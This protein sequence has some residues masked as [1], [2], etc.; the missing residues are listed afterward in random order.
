MIAGTLSLAIGTTALLFAVTES[1]VLRPFPFPQLDR[2]VGIGAAFPAAN[3]PLKFFEALSAPEY[4][5]I[6]AGARALTAV[7]GFDLNNE[8][9]VVNGQPERVFTAFV[10]D[11]PFAAL[12]VAPVAGRAITR[13]ELD[14]NAPVAVVSHS[15][16]LSHFAGD[17]R[18]VGAPVK[19]SGRTCTIVGVMPSR[20]RVYGTDLWTPMAERPETLPRDRRQFNVIARIAPGGSLDDA[21][22][23]LEVIAGRMA[24]EHGRAV[25]EYRGWSLTARRW[26]E[27]DGSP[28]DAALMTALAAATLVLLL[29][30]A[31]VA[32]M[33]LATGMERSRDMAVRASLGASRARL[34]TEALTERL[35]IVLMGGL[36]GVV[37]MLWGLRALPAML[38]DSL[39][40]PDAAL[41]ADGAV[42]AFLVAILAVVSLVVG[43][44]PAA[45]VTRLDPVVLLKNNAPG[46]TGSATF[47]RLQA[48][49][50]GAQVATALLV[51]ASTV[52][53]VRSSAALA[54]VDP[55]FDPSNLVTMRVSLPLQQYDGAR[56][57]QFFDDVLDRLRAVPTVVHATAALQHAPFAFSTA[58]FEIAGRAPGRD[59][60]LPSAF[61]TVTASDYLET[62]GIPLERGRWLLDRADERAP[63]EAVV[64][65]AAAS[66]YFGGA[67]AIGQRLR[68][69]GQGWGDGWMEIVGVAGNVRNRGLAAD[70][71]PEILVSVRQAPARRRSQLYIV[72]R[73]Q[74]EVGVAVSAV[75]NIVRELDPELPVYGVSSVEQIFQSNLTSRRL[76]AWTLSGFGVLAVLLSGLG[77]YAL[78]SRGMVSRRREIG[79]RLALGAAPGAVRRL[80]ARDALVPVMCGLLGG[81]LAAWA[82]GRAIA[83]A[84]FGLHPDGAAVASA[85][86]IL[87]AASA[88]GAVLPARRAVRVPPSEA[89]RCT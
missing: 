54:R 53:L 31:N 2:L 73:T 46:S 34:L 14:R 3:Q 12:Q 81:A 61:V 57:V 55:M 15:F 72:A 37:L 50:V 77:V 20:A 21:R 7:T 32:A 66:R 1:V 80:V 48:W 75:R 6:K 58:R 5:D 83:S 64:N 86:A 27:V 74:G 30:S 36:G 28:F 17:P 71:H 38:P 19:V 23:D 41:R 63:L 76:A 22:A 24:A 40:P 51:L 18:V 10:W 42:V 26:T 62:F 33:S 13:D 89:F 35:M 60:E 82:G 25:P 70:P 16:W 11:D 67:S 52:L 44:L 39:V 87:A 84:M 88:A 43:F 4:A 9:V 78:L 85:V 56:A 47:R 69:R 8:Q 68:V 79:I 45:A 65:A 49:L 59:G 29:A